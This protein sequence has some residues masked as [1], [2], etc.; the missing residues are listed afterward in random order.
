MN[1]I[2]YEFF[3]SKRFDI[4]LRY[5]LLKE[6]EFEVSKAR[7]LSN[8]KRYF[9]L[10]NVISKVNPRLFKKG[11]FSV[12]RWNYVE[13]AIA[14]RRYWLAANPYLINSVTSYGSDVKRLL[15]AIKYKKKLHWIDNTNLKEKSG[16]HKE[17]YLE[18]LPQDF[19]K[20]IQISEHKMIEMME[21]LSFFDISH[22]STRFSILINKVRNLFGR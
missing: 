16:F 21:E 3:C 6:S 12:Q 18:L 19:I 22:K 11:I 5:H 2:N 17:D 9:F 14:N 10:K 13:D 20:E 4:V 1:P 15:L 8:S 7:N